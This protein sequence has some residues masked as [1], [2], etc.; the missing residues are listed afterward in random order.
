MWPH[1]KLFLRSVC[2]L[3]LEAE[4][5]EFFL[6]LFLHRLARQNSQALTTKISSFPSP[7]PYF[8]GHGRRSL[9][10]DP[11][12]GCL[13]VYYVQT[14]YECASE[15]WAG[16]GSRGLNWK[17]ESSHQ[18]GVVPPETCVCGLGKS[19]GKCR[20]VLPSFPKFQLALFNGC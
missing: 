13:W 20:S 18:P 9:L 3:R 2:C 1:S 15:G 10:Q 17:V 5:T 6:Q 16:T 12:A 8:Q 14:R 19:S 7:H 11:G 4:T